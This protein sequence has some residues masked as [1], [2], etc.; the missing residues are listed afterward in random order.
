[1][2]WKQQFG[3]KFGHYR[4][5]VADKGREQLIEPESTQYLSLGE[6]VDVN[7]DLNDWTAGIK[8]SIAKANSHKRKNEKNRTSVEV[9]THRFSNVHYYSN[10]AGVDVKHSSRDKKWKLI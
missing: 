8:S 2:G 4:H 5:I 10:A 1:M 9:P 7:V 3:Q 6:G